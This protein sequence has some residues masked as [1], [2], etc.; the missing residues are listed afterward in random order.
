ME[1]MHGLLLVGLFV[2]LARVA[3]FPLHVRGLAA[4]CGCGT[5][6]TSFGFL[7]ILLSIGQNNFSRYYLTP[8]ELFRCIIRI[9]LTPLF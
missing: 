9:L 8:S 7:N 6:W 1:K 5:P 3:F 2:C 4:A